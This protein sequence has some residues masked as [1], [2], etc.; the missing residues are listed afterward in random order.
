M[1]NE[2]AASSLTVPDPGRRNWLVACGLALAAPVTLGQ[3]TPAPAPRLR[4]RTRRAVCDCAGEL[5]EEA[6]ERAHAERAERAQARRGGE[7]APAATPASAAASGAA[8]DRT[9]TTTK[10]RPAP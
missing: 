9:S 3:T 2:P 10:R 7:A 1:S 4:F 6:I 8:A 5:D